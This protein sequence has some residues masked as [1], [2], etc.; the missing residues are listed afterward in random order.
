MIGWAFALVVQAAPVVG[1]PPRDLPTFVGS[2]LNLCR[3]NQRPWTGP[4]RRVSDG[5]SR[6]TAADGTVM[7]TRT[8]EGRCVVWAPEWH[9]QGEQLTNS[10]R[11]QLD[12]WDTPFTIVEWRQAVASQDGPALWTV[13]EQ[14]TELGEVVGRIDVVEPPEGARG[15]ARVEYQAVRP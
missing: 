7:F 9:S 11:D 2:E 15:L 4:G 14:R 12:L 13:F 8:S 10:V 6:G 5:N 1:L 3:I